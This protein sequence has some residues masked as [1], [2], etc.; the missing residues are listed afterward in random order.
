VSSKGKRAPR[1]AGARAQRRADA[2]ATEKLWRARERL[3]ALEPSGS[4]ERPISVVSAS[5]IEP[6]ASTLRCLAC[7]GAVRIEDHAAG[8]QGGSVL[9]TVRV[10]CR[11]CGRPR[12]VYFRVS[13]PA[14]H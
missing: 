6:H 12:V 8:M 11:Q 9:R 13:P 5:Q 7:D 14:V 2:R 4:P 1:A 3:A 10:V